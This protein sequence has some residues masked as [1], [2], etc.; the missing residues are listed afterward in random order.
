LDLTLPT[1]RADFEL[2]ETYE[3]HP[4]SPLECPMTI[5]G[6]LEDRE[7]EAERLAAWS[8][9]TAGACEIRMFPGGHFYLNSSRSIFLQTFAGDLLRS[10]LRN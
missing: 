1:I 8:E 3:Y 6:G 9:M 7:V 10:C 4:E 2:Y 5:Y